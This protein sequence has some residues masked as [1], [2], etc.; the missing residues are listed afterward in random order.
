MIINSPGDT[1]NDELT[2]V[3]TGEDTVQS[4]SGT[5]KPGQYTVPFEPVGRPP[6]TVEFQVSNGF[7]TTV[8]SPD[9]LLTFLNAGGGT[10]PLNSPEGV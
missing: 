7:T 8:E 2:W 3:Q 4:L 5:L 1:D 9:T 6:Y 10:R